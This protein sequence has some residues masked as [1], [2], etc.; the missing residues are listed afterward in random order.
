MKQVALCKY[1]LYVVHTVMRLLLTEHST[2]CTIQ[3][4]SMKAICESLHWACLLNCFLLSLS[5]GRSRVPESLQLSWSQSVA[6]CIAHNDWSTFHNLYDI[7]NSLLKSYY[8]EYCMQLYCI[9]CNTISISHDVYVHG[10]LCQF[11]IQ[12]TAVIS[13]QYMQCRIDSQHWRN[14]H[15]DLLEVASGGEISHWEG[16]E[17]TLYWLGT[18]Y[19]QV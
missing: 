7:H 11:N 13:I 18:E 6:N 14:M 12:K 3:S 9:Y 4:C 17:M 16:E 19:N 5:A 10:K 8:D 2:E 1:R 15:A